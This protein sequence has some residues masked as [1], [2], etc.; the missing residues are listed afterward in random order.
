MDATEL[1]T[2]VGGL[3]SASRQYITSDI[4][5]SRT[6]ATKYYNREPFGNEQKGRSNF[7]MA[8][9]HD[10]VQSVLPAMLR[11]IFGPERPV[12]F[13]ATRPETVDQADQVT[14]FMRYVFEKGDGFLETHGNILNGLI[15]RHGIWKWG[16]DESADVCHERFVGTQDEFAEL[17]ANTP[18][19][20]PTSVTDNKDG[21]ITAEYTMT[22]PGGK[23]WFCNLPPEEFIAVRESRS[24]RDTVMVAH[25]TRVTRGELVELGIPTSSPKAPC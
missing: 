9:V 19:T 4:T 25:Q 12:E 16:W 13:A 18:G 3:V 11:Q 10:S 14:D 24:L 17:L 20:D 15:R 5:P 1:Q 6:L 21:T 22:Y 7:I 23:P 8:E 2:L